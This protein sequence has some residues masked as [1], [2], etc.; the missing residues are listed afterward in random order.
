MVFSLKQKIKQNKIVFFFLQKIRF[1]VN[2]VIRPRMF[3]LILNNKKPLS[4]VYGLDRGTPIDRY[5]IEN[6]L[7]SN[8]DLIRGDCLELLNNNYTKKFGE[9]R[10]NRSDVLDIDQNN[11]QATIHSDLRNLDSISDNQYDCII[12][13]QVFQFID[14]VPAAIKECYRI[15]KSGGALLITVPALGRID[16]VGGIDGDYWRFTRASLAYLLKQSFPE[17]NLTI[18]SLGNVLASVNFLIGA[19]FEESKLNTNFNDDNFPL[20]ITAIAKK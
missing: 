5:Y 8:K 16:C 1:F 7:S 13:T 11:H 3:Y 10:V 19:S 17:N 6:F 14:D 2:K 4:N 15:L 18:N 12:L 9:E 20:I